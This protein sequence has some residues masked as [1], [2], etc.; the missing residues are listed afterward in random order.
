MLPSVAD[1][2]KPH[3]PDLVAVG[4][5]GLGGEIRPVPQLERRLAE[6][7]RLGFRAAVVPKRSAPEGERGVIAAATLR[8]AIERVMDSD[9]A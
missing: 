9:G 8:E 7:R 5:I 6:A 3:R 4:E 2:D 1:R